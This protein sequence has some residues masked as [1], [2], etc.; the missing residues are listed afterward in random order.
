MTTLNTVVIVYKFVGHMHAVRDGHRICTRKH[1]RP[2]ADLEFHHM[3][4]YQR[5]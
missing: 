4:S 2:A 3:Y 1:S 5:R